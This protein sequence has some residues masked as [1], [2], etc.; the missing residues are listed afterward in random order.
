M[1]RLWSVG[2]L[3]KIRSS[4]LIRSWISTGVRVGQVVCVTCGSRSL[5]QAR[6]ASV[7]AIASS[8]CSHSCGS[9]GGVPSP[10]CAGST[11]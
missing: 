7:V 6:R 2:A 1:I 5:S 11:W 10:G 9:V 4:W 8:H 3:A